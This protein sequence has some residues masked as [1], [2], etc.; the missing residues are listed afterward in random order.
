MRS[1]LLAFPRGTSEGRF[2]R[3]GRYRSEEGAGLWRLTVRGETRTAWDVEASL[4]TL[5]ARF[6]PCAV[7]ANGRRLAADAWTF[8]EASGVLR[9]RVEGRAVRLEASAACR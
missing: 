8:D 7:A 4:R 2:G 1:Q 6:A 5:A 3:R 9:V